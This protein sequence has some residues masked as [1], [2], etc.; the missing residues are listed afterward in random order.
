MIFLIPFLNQLIILSRKKKK[1]SCCKN[2]YLSNSLLFSG[3]PISNI[4]REKHFPQI[5]SLTRTWA[6]DICFSWILE[7]NL[8][9]SQRTLRCHLWQPLG[10]Q[11]PTPRP[12]RW[13][14]GGQCRTPELRMAHKGSRTAGQMRQTW[15]KEAK[16]CPMGALSTGFCLRKGHWVSSQWQQVQRGRE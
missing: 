13:I 6:L 1:L 2:K 9:T 10:K 14:W 8:Y 11:Q 4:E 12:T 15:P 5:K 3:Q 7:T 16:G